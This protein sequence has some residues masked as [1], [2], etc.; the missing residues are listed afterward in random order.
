MALVPRVIP[1][2]L[3]KNQGLVKTIGFKNPVYLGDPINVVRIFND[4]E[5][6][7]IA[8]LD[9]S[10]SH[11]G[12]EPNLE[13][14]SEIASE[15]FAPMAYGGGVRD[16]SVAKKILSLGF[17]KIV[18][19]SV[20]F[21]KPDFIKEMAELFGSQSVVV[22]IDV[23]KLLLGGY[24]IM[25]H[26]G[27]REVK[28]ELVEWAQRFQKLGAGEILI[29][30]ID[31][32]GQ[33]KGYDVALIRRITEAVDVPVV[34]CGGAANLGDFRKAIVEGGASAVAAGSMF[35]FQGVHRAVLISFPERARL[36]EVFA[37]GSSS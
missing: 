30:S 35:V 21:E 34:A 13:L 2:L 20:A 32:D 22:S 25:T 14:L 11:E 1:A 16:I 23:R 36:E 27:G 17:E 37:D 28:G 10:A 6:D 4:K 5:I 24:R 31:R 18:V 3:L 15:C 9:I 12:K 7:E 26:G 19:N 33:M 8:L 29:N